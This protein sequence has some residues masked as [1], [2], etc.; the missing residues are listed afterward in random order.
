MRVAVGFSG[1]RDSVAA[2]LLLQ[3][4]GHRV[5]ALTLRLGVPGEDDRL[6]VS[7]RLAKRMR[8][9]HRVVDARETFLSHVI[10]PFLAGYAAGITPNPCVLCNARIKFDFLLQAAL[11]NGADRLATGHYARLQKMDQRWL[12][13]EPLQA[14]K[15]QVYFLAMVDP[16]RMQRVCFPLA[17]VSFETVQRLTHGFSV[18]IGKS[19]QDVCFIGRRSLED[20]LRQHISSAFVPGP[21]LNS[22]EEEIG[23][24]QGLAAVTIGQRRGLG[25]AAGKPLYVV[26]KDVARNA[27]IL[28]EESELAAREIT[29]STPNY[30]LPLQAG[31][32]VE[33]RI[34]YGSPKTP[35]VMIRA[36]AV[37]ITAR[38][39][40][41]V[42]ALTDGQLGVFYREE[43]VAAA[44]MID[45]AG[46]EPK[47]G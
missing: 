9:P 19:S 27:V 47:R 40:A 22:R 14:D 44:G 8:I 13:S 21:I 30:W 28:G 1:G 20:Y 15:S 46:G 25:Y 34:R 31:D 38:F 33:A 12:L 4:Q 24:H 29:V 35:A 32:R 10:Q 43:T 36:D 16:A 7:E 6:V 39:D 26:K 2:A 17:D 23:S 37:H 11:E 5:E 42:Q 41:P 18:V 3:E 45:S